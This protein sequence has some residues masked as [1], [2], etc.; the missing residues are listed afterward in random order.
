MRRVHKIN[1]DQ[2][3]WRR[4]RAF[5]KEKVLRLCAWLHIIGQEH[6]VKLICRCVVFV[7]KKINT[8]KLYGYVYK[9]SN[10]DF[11]ELLGFYFFL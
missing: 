2:K 3:F 1:V 10:M 7:N 8:H 6:I 5:K 9:V 11:K 4:H